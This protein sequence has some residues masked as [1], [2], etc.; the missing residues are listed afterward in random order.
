MRFVAYTMLVDFT[1]HLQMPF[2]LDNFKRAS[3][4]T[5]SDIFQMYISPHTV[6][7]GNGETLLSHSHV[8]Y[9]C[10]LY[11]MAQ[12]WFLEKREEKSYKKYK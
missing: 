5:S 4:F 9:Q 6:D 11:R 8:F 12:P 2:F 10:I 7:S 3:V 1:K